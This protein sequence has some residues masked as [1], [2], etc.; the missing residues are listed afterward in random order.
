MISFRLLLSNDAVYR[1]QCLPSQKLNVVFEHV[2]EFEGMG[3]VY[4]KHV[5]SGA[6]LDGGE[7]VSA[8]LVPDDIVTARV[9]TLTQVP[10]TVCL[11]FN[12]TPDSAS[13]PSL[14]LFPD[15][16]LLHDLDQHP[17]SA[18]PSSP[19]GHFHGPA[20][21]DE[22]DEDNGYNNDRDRWRRAHVTRIESSAGGPSMLNISPMEIEHNTRISQHDLV[23]QAALQ[24]TENALVLQQ[25]LRSLYLRLRSNQASDTAAAVL[26]LIRSTDRRPVFLHRGID[27]IMQGY[28][29]C[30]KWG[31]LWRT[32]QRCW[33]VLWDSKMSFF[34]SPEYAK[35]YMFALSN[36]RRQKLSPLTQDDDDAM[37]KRIQ[38]DYAPH[39]EL[40][41]SGWSA[42]PGAPQCD[43]HTFA[44]FDQ[45]G[46]LRQ[47]LDVSTAAETVA[48]VR[49]IGSQA[50]QHLVRL[51]TKLAAASATE[52]L[53]ILRLGELPLQNEGTLP[54]APSPLKICV[55][56][57]WLH[58]HVES[59][60]A[61]SR[62]RRMKCSNFSQAVKDIQRDVLRINGHLHASSCFEDMLSELA[63]E[64][65]Q[66]TSRHTKTSEMDA[67]AFARQ[68]LILSSRT[69]GGGDVL[70]AVHCLLQSPHFC[71][72]PEMSDAAPVDVEIQ[73][74]DGKTVVEIEMIMVFKVIP[75]GSENAIG[76][77]VGT[78][79][80]R[81]I[82]DMTSNLDVDGEIRIAV[83]RAGGS[84]FR[85]DG[86]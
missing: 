26:K 81:L 3:K 86:N 20:L 64:L 47:V 14:D 34:A 2:S 83:E 6:S 4:L 10:T 50:Q 60:D 67:M 58:V 69:H 46:T 53:D 30:G 71:I 35:K 17:T 62:L 38:K 68:L 28:V 32:K 80:Q 65:L 63:I 45:G 48:W 12:G 75:N 33:A 31:A 11:E 24:L 79:K 54:C 51:Q 7:T 72:C 25:S 8:V 9:D 16:S 52:Y 57:K 73:L 78:S 42:R 85:A 43:R 77:I 15:S 19:S 70:D 18:V 21:P 82:C 76:H 74:I 23:L 59:Q 41:V 61:S 44:L 49:A 66:H 27:V 40:H 37:G 13:A 36:E 22:Y 5:R 39:T 56:L 29:D 84:S 55:P 1:F